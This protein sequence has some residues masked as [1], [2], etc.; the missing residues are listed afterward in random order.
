MR[1]EEELRAK[2][3]FFDSLPKHVRDIWNMRGEKAAMQVYRGGLLPVEV[4]DD[5]PE[6]TANEAFERNRAREAEK[7]NREER[8]GRCIAR[9]VGKADTY[10][11]RKDRR[12]P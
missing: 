7:A 8:A 4:E 2:M 1:D 10:R 12:G 6:V 3:R 5:Y 9:Q 11:R